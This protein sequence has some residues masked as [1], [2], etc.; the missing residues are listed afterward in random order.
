LKHLHHNE[1]FFDLN[2]RLEYGILGLLLAI[3]K[4]V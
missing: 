2:Q 4:F 3:H 1:Y